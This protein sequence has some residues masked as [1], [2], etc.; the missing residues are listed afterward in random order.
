MNVI[1]YVWARTSFVGFHYWADA[2]DEVKFLRDAHRHVFHV[3]LSVA[4][5]KDREVEFLTLK[6]RL[7]VYLREVYEGQ[8]FPASCERIAKTLMNHFNADIVEVSEDGECGATVVR[9]EE[10]G[11]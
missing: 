4:T 9:S 5:S 11:N 8:T 7:D 3:K 10:E 2:P 6:R 1:Q